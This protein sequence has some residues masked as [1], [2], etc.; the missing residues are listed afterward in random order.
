MSRLLLCR[1][2]DNE[3]NLA[4]HAAHKAYDSMLYREALKAGWYDL[5]NA[6]DTYRMACGPDGM[7]RDLVQRYM[8]VSVQPFRSAIPDGMYAPCHK[9]TQ[10]GLRAK[11]R[12][13][14]F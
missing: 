11:S 12:T 5:H 8:E 7:H 1:V 3:L 14:R 2:F 9:A 10:F 4:V 6:R 13:Q